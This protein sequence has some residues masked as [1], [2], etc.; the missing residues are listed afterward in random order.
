MPAA[1]NL[2]EVSLPSVFARYYEITL[3]KNMVCSKIR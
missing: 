1:K 3:H 2:D